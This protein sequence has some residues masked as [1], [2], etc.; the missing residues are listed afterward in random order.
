MK[1]FIIFI[2]LF[3]SGCFCLYW[4]STLINEGIKVSGIILGKNIEYHGKHGNQT[5]YVMAISPFDKKTYKNF[6]TC[7][8]FSTYCSF[9]KGETITFLDISPRTCLREYE[10]DI[11]KNI[12]IITLFIL[13]CILIASSITVPF[14]I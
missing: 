7:V 13:G 3:I 2:L 10:T 12:L 4:G 11:W 1:K 14:N 5:R 8:D 9:N 6:E